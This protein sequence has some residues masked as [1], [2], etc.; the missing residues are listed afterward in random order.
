MK[1]DRT[2]YTDNNQIEDRDPFSDLD[3]FRAN[4]DEEAIAV[5]K[6]ITR[7]PVRKPGNQ[8]FFRVH[9]DERFRMDSRVLELKEERETYFVSRALL[10]EVIDETRL[11]RIYTV[12][13]KAGSVFLWPVPLPGPDGRRNGWHDSAHA[14]AATAIHNWT[15]IKADMEAGQYETSIAVAALPEPVWPYLKFD[16]LIRLAFKDRIIDDGDHPVIRRLRGAE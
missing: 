1:S 5:R 3:Q 11:V 16:D 9:D 12:I 15:R 6:V 10:G 7:V 4:P 14:A 8:E 13:S 2:S